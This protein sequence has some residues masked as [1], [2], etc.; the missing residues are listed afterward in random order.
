MT[1]APIVRLT[2]DPPVPENEKLSWL[3]TGGPAG[4]TTARE[5]TAIS[6]ATAAL[7]GKGG[8]P[9]TQ[10]MAERIGLD[11]ISLSRRQGTD[12]SDP[13]GAQVVTLGKRV[14]ERVYLAFEQGLSAASTAIKIEYVIS[15]Y[16][17]VSAFAGADNGLALNFRRNWP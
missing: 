13:V 17:T 6:A 2:S 16:L 8:R 15:R 14:T 10:R 3:I 9:P 7:F 1:R 5:S 4:S 12:S 11:D